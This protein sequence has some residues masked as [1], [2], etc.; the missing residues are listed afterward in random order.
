MPNNLE[1]QLQTEIA[2]SSTESKYNGLSYALREVI[3]IMELLEEMKSFGFPIAGT[4]SKVH[5]QHFED[6]SGAL[7]TAKVHK[8]RPRTKHINVKMHHFKDYVTRKEISIHPIRTT[9][10]PTDFLMKPLND[11]LLIKHR[12][13]VMGW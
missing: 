9:E 2:L 6:N 10:Q 4:T 12:F 7:E 3:P 13:T 11:I 1:S 5:C 8:F